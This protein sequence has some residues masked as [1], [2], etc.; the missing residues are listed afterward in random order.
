M[1]I[2]KIKVVR[3]GAGVVFVDLLTGLS[4]LLQAERMMKVTNIRLRCL[5]KFIKVKATICY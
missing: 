3:L 4:F 5:L 2:N 1:H